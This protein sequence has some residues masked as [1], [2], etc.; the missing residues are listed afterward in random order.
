MILTTTL[1]A[2]A[3]AALINFW[4]MIRCSSVRVS[5]RIIHGDDGNSLMMKR[6]RAHANFTE[7]A[8][9]VL[10]LIGAAV[11]AGAIGDF[12]DAIVIAIVVLLNAC[13]GFFQEHRAEAA[14]AA[15]KA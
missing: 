4:L 3:A 9:L 11:L 10:I 14:L 1:S 6:M 8:P 2:A 12:K 13:L 5:A 15:L 7:S